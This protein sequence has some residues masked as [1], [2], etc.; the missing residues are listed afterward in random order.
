VTAVVR[1]VEV[2]AVPAPC[3]FGL[4]WWQQCGLG[5]FGAW[6]LGEGKWRLRWETQVGHYSCWARFLGH[7]ERLVRSGQ[8][9]LET[10]AERA[11]RFSLG[12]CEHI[13]A[14]MALKKR[15]ICHGIESR[16][17]AGKDLLRELPIFHRLFSGANRRVAGDHSESLHSTISSARQ[18]QKKKIYFLAG[19]LL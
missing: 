13:V 17:G 7:V 10:G 3:G 5:Q 4:A 8:G 16:K 6:V 2:D 11:T 9:V 1:A 15:K 14:S 12:E 19:L 18:Q